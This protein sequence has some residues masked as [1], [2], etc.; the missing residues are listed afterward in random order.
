M[1]IYKESLFFAGEK[2]KRQGE[3]TLEK[4]L[5]LTYARTIFCVTVVIVHSMTGFI[6]DPH[7]TELQS[8]ITHYIQILLLS[9]TP[10]FI[11]LSELLLGMRYSKHIPKNFLF[12]RVKFILIPY[13]F[14][15]LFVAFERYF[16]PHNHQTLWFQISDILIKGRFFGW[17]V[18]VIFQF[19][20]LHMLFYKWLDKLKPALPIII[21]FII[22]FG[23]ALLMYY[24]QSYVGWWREHYPLF[25][26]T[27]I[28]NWLFYFVIGFYIGKNYEA[29]MNYIKGKVRYILLLL[30]VN[31]LVI[32]FNLFYLKIEWTESNRFD[33]FIFTA[34][35]FMLT[36]YISK[37][38]SKFHLTIFYLISE[39]SFFIYLSHQI[40]IQHI[41]RGLVS[42]VKYPPLFFVL[43]VIFTLGFCIVLAIIISFFSYLRIIVG[44]NTLY[45]MVLNNYSIKE[46][47]KPIIETK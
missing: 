46:E 24:S 1:P 26:R 8:N 22:S 2:T 16:D 5:E 28:L 14:F 37:H 11:M 39:I 34:S 3:H 10:C 17:F 13:I 31:A 21:S 18:I 6:H 47:A 36:I 30:L 45:P 44:R 27:I 38:L 25:T 43:L 40:I 4:K 7:V 19:F 29:V 20:I 42:F 15:A 23:H 41:S 9:A 32:A 12:K 35:L 33:L